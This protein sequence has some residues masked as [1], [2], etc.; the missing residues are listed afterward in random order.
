MIFETIINIFLNLVN[1][2][3]NL[4]PD[5]NISIPSGIVSNISNFISGVTYFF[6]I[7]ALL[8]ILFISLSITGFRIIYSIFLVIKSF[9][10]TISGSA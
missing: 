10:P 3:L 1:V 8:P 2:L 5:I 4:L 9:I 7:K 6:P